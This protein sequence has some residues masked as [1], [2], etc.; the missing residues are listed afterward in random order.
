[1]KVN[2][3][4]IFSL[5]LLPHFLLG[6]SDD[7][8]EITTAAELKTFAANGVTNVTP[9]RLK[10]TITAVLPGSF[11]I[12]DD[13]GWM[14]IQNEKR[15]IVANGDQVVVYGKTY[16][17]LDM[18]P[19]HMYMHYAKGID[20]I[21]HGK[22]RKPTDATL[23]EI[24]SGSLDGRLV[25][26]KGL[27]VSKTI[28]EIDKAFHILLVSADRKTIAIFVSDP[29]IKQTQL[30][31]S[32][33]MVE[34]ICIPHAGH[35]RQFQGHLVKPI[36]NGITV[37]RPP[38]SDPFD[39]PPMDITQYNDPDDIV[40]LGMRRI[41]G[42]VLAVWNGDRFLMRTGERQTTLALLA[43]GIAPPTCG[44]SVRVAGFPDTDLFNLQLAN[45]I[46]RGR[47]R[48][49]S[50]PS[51][52]PNEK[53]KDIEIKDIIRGPMENH[54]L[55]VPLH[56]RLVRFRGV[57]RNVPSLDFG[58]TQMYLEHDTCVVPV[59][60]NGV[61]S[62][63]TELSIGCELE[64]TGICV[65]EAQEWRP[66]VPMP[67]VRKL[68]IVPRSAADIRIVARPPWWTTG[69]LMVALGIL[70]AALLAVFAWNRS[71]SHA[72]AVR[73]RRLFREELA[74]AKAELKIEERTRL[75]VELHDSLSQTL[76]GVAF[77]I[78]A[79]E[80]ARQKNPERVERHLSAAQKTLSSCR[81]ELTNC[82]SDLRS[83]TFEEQDTEKAIR[84]MLEPHIEE[85]EVSVDFKV[86]R[87]HLSDATF[88][89]IL[90]MTRELVVNA[91]RHGKAQHVSVTG[92]IDNHCIF[93]AVQDDGAGF[94]PANR[95]GVSEGHFG[96]KGVSERID[97]LG[98]T[99]E[100]TSAP[101]KG[102]KIDIKIERNG[103]VRTPSAP[104]EN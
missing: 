23:T 10:G 55:N 61:R 101:G 17:N 1:M 18:T 40:G 86:P 68:Y 58:Q 64:I 47:A 3:T 87:T 41:D 99:M 89:A 59:D 11:T 92:G 96:L 26:I 71:L 34:G 48:S 9:F 36:E 49:P 63:V 15:I 27:V 19:R 54:G 57:V 30:V 93:L 56:G 50:A 78:E 81:R 88:H 104:E 21:G 37:I 16:P 76:T 97:R 82:L 67:K 46:W 44:E 32:E 65:L 70:A 6:A 33:I 103:R 8:A 35:W 43:P 62:C 31:N 39:V 2:A 91:I 7:V 42:T 4:L 80:R 13:T 12:E 94:D 90:Q 38:P 66:N 95:P 74:H 102:T 53:P 83:R 60:L 75:A 29:N 69:R 100:I 14:L 85:A 25:R 20:I 98:G 52:P 24:A 51:D 45:A 84:L 77:Q 22:P 5:L 79:A 73:G 28:D 72:V